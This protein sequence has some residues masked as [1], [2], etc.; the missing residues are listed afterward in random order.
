M[1]Q[2]YVAPPPQPDRFY[3][4]ITIPDRNRSTSMP[5]HDLPPELTPLIEMFSRVGT[6]GK[7]APSGQPCSET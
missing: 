6:V 3:Y 7:R 4:E 5:E 2:P 1:D